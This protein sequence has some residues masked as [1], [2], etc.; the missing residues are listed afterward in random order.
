MG[1]ICLKKFE[2]NQ[3]ESLMN[4]TMEFNQ[5]NFNL[6]DSFNQILEN[7]NNFSEQGTE[8]IFNIENKS[9]IPII[10]NDIE[11]SY[12]IADDIISQYNFIIGHDAVLNDTNY[13]LNNEEILETIEKLFEKKEE[14]EKGIKNI[15]LNLD[16]NIMIN[17]KKNNENGINN[18]DELK[19]SLID[20]NIE[21]NELNKLNYNPISN[22][23]E[24]INLFDNDEKKINNPQKRKSNIMDIS[25]LK[26]M[27]TGNNSSR[28]NKNY[29]NNNKIKRNSFGEV[30]SI[31]TIPT[32]KN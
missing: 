30:K 16:N 4:D 9:N 26:K 11:N 17:T 23:G 21:N 10:N 29:D 18:E 27:L 5:N 20:G 28:K 1:L 14:S 19:L 31:K 15:K 2:K 13:C 8:L 6:K 24:D 22:F 7:I 3:N 32:K 25:S 12:N